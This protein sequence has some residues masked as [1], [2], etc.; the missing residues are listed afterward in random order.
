MKSFAATIQNT[1]C[2]LNRLPPAVLLSLGFVLGI[3]VLGNGIW[4]LPWWSLS[5]LSVLFVL[6][7]LLIKPRYLWLVAGLLCIGVGAWRYAG[8]IANWKE[9]RHPA[10]QFGKHTIVAEVISEPEHYAD[11]TTCNI[12]VGV[13]D[14][15][16]VDFTARLSVYSNKLGSGEIYGDS[17]GESIDF[18]DVIS[19]EARLNTPSRQS[20]PFGFDYFNY[21][22]ARKL[23]FLATSYTGDQ[24]IML[25]HDQGNPIL[26]AAFA[27]RRSFSRF[28]DENIPEQDAQLAKSVFLGM[29]EAVSDENEEFFRKA[30]VMHI[31]VVSGQNL[32][33]IAFL[34]FSLLGLTG[35]HRRW[36]A[37]CTIPFIVFYALLTGSDPPVVRACIMATIVLVGLFLGKKPPLG[38]A[39]GATALFVLI[40]S[41]LMLFEASFV[42]SFS[43]TIGIAFFMP[44]FNRVLRFL[45]DFLRTIFSATLGAQVA[46]YPFIAFYFYRLA[47]YSVPA[48]LIIVPLSDLF[49]FLVGA[50]LAVGSLIPAIAGLAG[51]LVG[52]V[53]WLLTTAANFFAELPA[54]EVLVGRPSLLFIIVFFLVVTAVIYL[55]GRW[56]VW[57]GTVGVVMLLLLIVFPQIFKWMQPKAEGI[58]LDIGQGDSSVL[59]TAHNKVWV[60]DTG[61]RYSRRSAAEYS[62]I[63]YLKGR[64][65]QHIDYLVLSHG[66]KDHTG[67]VS[68]L[69]DQAEVGTVIIPAAAHIDEY[70]WRDILAQCR[71]KKV[72]VQFVGEKEWLVGEG[73]EEITIVEPFPEANPPNEEVRE[74]LQSLVLI[75]RFKSTEVL[76]TGDLEHSGM[77][78][79]LKSYHGS[80][81]IVKAPHHGSDDS[82]WEWV[83]MLKPRLV[84]Y[85]ASATAKKV[86]GDRM[87]EWLGD[88]GI[89]VEI[90]GVEGAL[91]WNTNGSTFS[92]GAFSSGRC[93]EWKLDTASGGSVMRAAKHLMVALAMWA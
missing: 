39:I 41:P 64:A 24:L 65:I 13:L 52:C 26:G 21:L 55:R 74:N 37:L 18:G 11:K 58:F 57:S 48:N 40:F 56:R 46:V 67:G 31:L 59:I 85:Q 7:L 88:A 77:I 71:E 22:T 25:D 27:L 68:T 36:A 91:A 49:M 12:R 87:Q 70:P 47:T 28:M 51:Q 19:V 83:W 6:P 50:L 4:Q 44:F 78:R 53:G 61:D 76:W 2:K 90:T 81:A 63:P 38:N 15:S 35:L 23:A 1:L 62:L 60:I 89:P 30:G 42:L 43:A 80:P 20:N 3:F 92:A 9:I 5:L 10:W 69:L 54:S 79:F 73:D 29:R 16:S 66:H 86:A 93:W 14:G 32:T 33:M 75:Y 17:S 34:V 45:P 84:V 82:G 72:S 8:E